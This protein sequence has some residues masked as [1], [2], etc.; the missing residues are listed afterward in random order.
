MTGD[1]DIDLEIQDDVHDRRRAREARTAYIMWRMRDVPVVYL[2]LMPYTFSAKELMTAE[3]AI[4]NQMAED[5]KLMLS[6][7]LDPGPTPCVLDWDGMNGQEMIE[8]GINERFVGMPAPVKPG[9][10][11]DGRPWRHHP[12]VKAAEARMPRTAEYRAA[13]RAMELREKAHELHHQVNAASA[14]ND[15][16]EVQR[17]EPL[18][19]EAYRLLA[20]ADA[21]LER[22]R[23]NIHEAMQM[24][25][26]E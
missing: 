14:A 5:L 23:Q 22:L 6:P 20:E 15:E 19:K 12:A 26:P 8:F 21:E 3:K 7:W 13:I 2:E 17:L 10:D 16:A 4:R 25:V 9:N 24:V 18:A 1:E 11:P